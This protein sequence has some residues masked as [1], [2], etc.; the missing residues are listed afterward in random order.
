VA[1]GGKVVGGGGGVCVP[2]STLSH[3]NSLTLTL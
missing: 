2:K 1:C 3:S